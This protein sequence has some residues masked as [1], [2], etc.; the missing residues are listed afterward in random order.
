MLS[1]EI[2]EERLKEFYKKDGRKARSKR[3]AKLP[4]KLRPVGYGLTGHDEKG[5]PALR[6]QAATKKTSKAAERF[7]KLSG[8]EQRQV[9]GAVVP[10]IAQHVQAGW[11]LLKSLPYQSGWERK[12]FRAPGDPSATRQRRTNWLARILH[13][14]EGYEEDVAWLAE[15]APYLGDYGAPLDEL[16]ILFA[17]TINNGGKE[18]DAVCEILRDSAGGQ[19]EIGSMGRH[20]TRALLSCSKPRAWEFTEKLLLAAQR[21]EGLRQTILETI[22]EAHPEAFLRMLKLILDE[23]LVRFSATVRAVDVWLSLQWDSV[24]TG[25][26]K[27][28]VAQLVTFLEDRKQREAALEGDDAE[29]AYYALWTIAFDDAHKAI[30]EAKKLLRHKKVEHRFVAMCLLLKLGLVDSVSATTQLLEDADLRLVMMAAWSVRCQ[31]GYC[32][33]E[34]QQGETRRPKDL[35]ERLEAVIDRFP[36]KKEKLKALVWPWWNMTAERQEVAEALAQNLGERSPTRLIP[37]LRDLD[38]WSRANVISQM[39]AS[40]KWDTQT[41]DTLFAMVGD[42]SSVVREAALKGIAKCKANEEE[43]LGFEKLLT[44]KSAD[45]RRGILAL[46]LK[47]TDP[48]TLASA[49][50]LTGGQQMQ[51]AAGLELLRLM[52]EAERSV[53]R[54][55]ELAQAYREKQKKL[56]ADETTLLDAILSQGQDVATLDDALGLCDNSARTKPVRPKRHKVVFVTKAAEACLESLDDLVHAHRET[57]IELE[58]HHDRGTELLGN[59]RWGFP[60]PKN[61]TPIEEDIARLPMADVWK[62][63]YDQ[64]PKKL[65]DKD[66]LELVRAK[67]IFVANCRYGKP[68]P[69]HATFFGKLNPDKLRYESVVDDLVSWLTRMDATPASHDYLLKAAETALAMVPEPELGRLTNERYSVDYYHLAWRRYDAP[70][71]QWLAMARNY[72]HDCLN[73]WTDDHAARFWQL[74]RWVD[75]PQ[76]KEVTLGGKAKKGLTV[77][78]ERPDFEILVR[79]LKAG[80][81]TEADAIDHLLG[82]RESS[83]NYGSSFDSLR[84][85]TSKKRPKEFADEKW[86]WPL[87]ELCRDRVLEIELAR[88]ETPTAATGA[89]SSLRSVW[90]ADNVLRILTALGKGAL[91]RGYSYDGGQNKNTIF[92]SLLRVCLPD[93]SDTAEDFQAKATAAGIKDERILDLAVYAPQWAR[94]AQHTLGWEGLEDAIWW[95]HAHTKDTGWSIDS[96]IREGWEASVSERTPLSSQD[97]LDGGVDVEWFHRVYDTLKKKRWDALLKSAKYAAGGGGHKRAELFASA[98]LGRE[99]KTDLVK[100]INDKRNQDSVRALGLLPLA[101]G[102]L[103]EKDLLSRYQLMQEFVRTSRQFG[104]QRQASEKRAAT[105]GQQNLARTAGYADPIRLQW[106]MEAHAVADLGD[107]PLT[108]AIDDVTVSLAIDRTGGIDFVIERAGKVLKSVPAVL[109]KNKQFKELRER[110]T[111]LKRQVSRTRP[112]LEQMMCRGSTLTGGE[113]VD[114]LGHAIIGPMLSRLVLVGEGDLGYAVQGGKAL[115]N[116]DG[117]LTAVKKTD[118]LRIAHPMDLYESGRWHHWQ[119]DCFAR[120]RIQPFKQVFRELY[121]VTEAELKDKAV[122]RRY[123]GHQVNP[124]QAL[125][126]LGSRGWVNVPEEGV[127]RTFHEEGLSAWLGFLEGFCT[128]ADVEGLTLEEVRFTDKRD[129][130]PLALKDMPPRLFSEVMRDLDLVVS[131]AH[132][133]GVDPEASASTIQ[134]RTDLMRET[135]AVL[136]IENIEFKKDHAII[137]GELG[138]YSVH[139]GS[140]VVHKMPGGAMLIVPIHSQHRGRIFL[141]FADDDPKTAEVLSKVLLLAR[142]GGIQ[143][144][145]ILEQIQMLGKLA[146]DRIAK[147]HPAKRAIAK[148]TG[149]RYF[150]LVDDKS[151]KFW[152][153]AVDGKEVAVRFGRIGA[154]GQTQ[155][156]TF[157]TPTEANAHAEKLTGQKTSKGYQEVSAAG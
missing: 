16:G 32:D 93:E 76:V 7:D 153:V 149:K 117:D 157:E 146:P 18:G 53:D 62:K 89:A 64:R 109:K 19:H 124:R 143:D 115:E 145:N 94:F 135:L 38:T 63:W 80:A 106:A 52:V 39:A 57:P 119:K 44:R 51:R 98:L 90:G 9:L 148:E 70:Y 41:R 86:L 141:P 85:L 118:K 123:A 75:E 122:S 31:E 65:H 46:L 136:S 88:G 131:V 82:S 14:T 125:A 11:D 81:A 151:S 152:E 142:D 69:K 33:V 45:L 28:T 36:K 12:P 27:K 43:V 26:V 156:K 87:V 55:Q 108:L 96:E 147:K 102:K 155:V 97:L 113:L 30:P 101:G 130:K 129:P 24:S 56:S 8:A 17:A 78:R 138:Q 110:R 34:L 21:Q 13:A 40:K 47:Q 134:M 22:D 127:R 91:V 35:F 60:S 6:D 58:E 83:G 105:I 100:N 128:P 133:G 116:C 111:E 79:A 103:R 68:H 50:R 99:K 121:P 54:C 140:G 3:V 71:V 66:G 77:P 23:N 132:R 92:S 137:R 48:Q 61:N 144:P 72:Q 49:Q 67:A 5:K 15:W 29:A 139:L 104:S 107:G 150:E 10:A 120:E 1:P 154:K 25:I 42:S 59:V 114:L 4:A 84:T 126:L 95:I 73:G 2:A 112:T 37:Y 20:V 74:H